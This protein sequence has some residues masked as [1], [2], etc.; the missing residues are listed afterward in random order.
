[1]K[2]GVYRKLIL[3]ALT[4]NIVFSVSIGYY[5][6]NFYIHTQNHELDERA[7]VLT[8]NLAYNSEFPVF[9]NDIEAI[10]WLVKG[11]MAQR[12]VVFCR[13]EDKDGIPL[14]QEGAYESSA[15]K[16]TAE[17][18]L[19][20]PM[21]ETTEELILG[22]PV[23]KKETIGRA[24]LAVSFSRLNRDVWNVRNN[25]IIIAVASAV[26][27]SLFIYVLIRRILGRPIT[28]LVNAVKGISEGNLAC[29]V[30]VRTRDEIGLLAA[31]FN[32]MTESLQNSKDRL[33]EAQEELVRKEKLAV[34][35]K[36]AGI[37]GHEIRNP[38]GV[39]NNAV[40][41][42]E[43]IHPDA[44][45]TTKEYLGIIRNGVEASERIVSDLLDFSRT[46]P[47]QKRPVSIPEFIAQILNKCAVPENITV[48]ME[49]P[50]TLPA[51]YADPVQMDQVFSN[52]IRNAVEAMPDGGILK[53]EA[54]EDKDGMMVRVDISDTG[55]GIPQENMKKLFQ[56]LFT[57]KTKGLG[58]GL[59]VVKNLT[60]A[61]GGRVEVKSDPWKGT[62]FAVL[63]PVEEMP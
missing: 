18:T 45:G 1:M 29:K 22:I 24:Y 55:H 30:T 38:L 48:K 33:L 11:V 26:V 34:L 62:T 53:I 25:T 14:Y 36:V 60:E 40:Y 16:Y 44:D 6:I 17:I 39:I 3:L 51:A 31:S 43:T 12:D 15:K 56:P 47:P 8:K 21:E 61:N 32:N 54:T 35:G 50:E 19:T 63:L 28:E 42:L 46:K 27:T 20:N 13:I 23:E 7:N 57:T 41:Y 10:I 59:T 49:M 37:V 9:I 2:F 5:F 4:V 52:I 58:F